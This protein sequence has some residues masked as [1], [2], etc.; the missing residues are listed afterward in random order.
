MQIY[1]LLSVLLE[2]PTQELI[3]H[4]DEVRAKLEQE[5]ES[6]DAERETLRAFLHHL[7][8]TPL[9]ELQADY[10]QTFDLTA[11]HSLHLTHHLFGDDRNRGPALIDLTELYKDYGVELATNELPDYLPLILEFTAYLD[12]NEATVF[13]A[14][15]GKVLGV[16]ADNLK[17]AESPYASLVAIVAERA[18]L[19][20]LAA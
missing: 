10:V 14:D 13:L 1:K 2:Y 20:R 17:K 16:L 12:E 3:D 4:L 19:P 5:V 8:E 11:E 6:S 18:R 15:A 7:A 9:T